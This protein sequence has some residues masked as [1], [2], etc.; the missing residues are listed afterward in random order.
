LD[1]DTDEAIRD[2]WFIINKDNIIIKYWEFFIIGLAIYNTVTVPLA[3]A[4]ED[5]F[6]DLF[7]AT[8]KNGETGSLFYF[9]SFVDIIYIIDIF[10]VFLTAYLDNRTGDEIKQPLKIA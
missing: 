9:D 5:D 4:F 10:V 8:D 6:G 7:N 2:R 1:D 3:K